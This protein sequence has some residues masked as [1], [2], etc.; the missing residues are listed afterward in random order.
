MLLLPA[1]LFAQTF[2]P[3]GPGDKV[4]V[5]ASASS[6]Y[7]FKTGMDGGGDVTIARYGVAVGS[8]VPLSDQANFGIRVNYLR[9]EFDFSGTNA[10][11]GPETLGR[12]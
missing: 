7:Q 8:G 5:S 6:S 10:F 2:D 11:S 4:R 1:N 3:Q 9:E 12:G